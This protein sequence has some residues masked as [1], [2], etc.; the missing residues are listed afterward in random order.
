MVDQDRGVGKARPS[1]VRQRVGKLCERGFG[2]TWS[3]ERDVS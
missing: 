2:R 1:A 3:K